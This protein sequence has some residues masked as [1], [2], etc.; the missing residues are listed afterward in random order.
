M[1]FDL[2]NWNVETVVLTDADGNEARVLHK[3]VPVGW[4]A[5]WAEVLAGS[6]NSSGPLADDADLSDL[7]AHW[8]K[9]A[10]A[11]DKTADEWA[12]FSRAVL[13]DLIV[14]TR[15]LFLGD[16]TD[17]PTSLD[18]IEA[19]AGY[20]PSKAKAA[21]LISLMLQVMRTGQTTESGNA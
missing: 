20:G 16:S 14:G 6:S 7:A 13:A 2:K 5:Q 10:E 1:G 11:G 12:A 19:L 15:D 21:P 8:R 18:L 4:R 3:P 9:A 17:A